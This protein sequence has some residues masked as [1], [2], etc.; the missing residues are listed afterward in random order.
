[1]TVARVMVARV[2]VA[3]VTVVL[4]TVARVTL[5]LG[6]GSRV[7][8]GRSSRASV[9]SGVTVVTRGGV[10]RSAARQVRIRVSRGF[11][12]SGGTMPGVEGPGVSLALGRTSSEASRTSSPTVDVP[13]EGVTRVILVTCVILV[14][15]A[16]S[17]RCRIRGSAGTA[18]CCR[19][20]GR[21]ESCRGWAGRSALRR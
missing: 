13:V 17:R 1:M 20:S 5:V 9:R 15:R 3:R 19:S 8:G 12:R 14:S 7:M 6:K 16:T 18:M 2:M 21:P 11:G 4:V 10:R